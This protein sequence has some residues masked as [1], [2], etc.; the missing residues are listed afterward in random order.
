MSTEWHFVLFD[1]ILQ[2]EQCICFVHCTMRLIYLYLARS[3]SAHDLFTR[4][5]S[6][7]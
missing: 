4:Q 3:E 1:S 5:D 6:A 2:Q 7:H